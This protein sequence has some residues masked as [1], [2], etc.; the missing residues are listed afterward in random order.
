MAAK[1]S[2][3][4][5]KIRRLELSPGPPQ[6]CHETEYL[7][8]RLLL[9]RVYLFRKLELDTKLH[10]NICLEKQQKVAQVLGSLHP[11]MRSRRSF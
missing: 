9:P 2:L 11:C 1:V 7:S 6:Q 5:I 10:A 4:Q 3:G 8:C